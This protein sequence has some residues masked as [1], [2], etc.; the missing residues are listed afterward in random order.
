MQ[1]KQLAFVAPF[2][3]ALVNGSPIAETNNVAREP[4]ETDADAIWLWKK[5]VA[6]EG[7]TMFWAGKKRDGAETDADNIWL[8]KTKRD[9]ATTD[10]DA[11]WLWKTKRDGATTDADAVWLWKKSK[12]LQKDSDD[13]WLW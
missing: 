1:L 4:A 5:H 3:L 7:N 10:S 13:V 11:I 9:G 6:T 12:Q 8:W 2:L